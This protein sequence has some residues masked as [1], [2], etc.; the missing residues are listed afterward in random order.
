MFLWLTLQLETMQGKTLDIA[1]K[2]IEHDFAISHLE[3]M[4]KLS[5]EQLQRRKELMDINFERNRVKFGDPDYIYD[6]QVNILIF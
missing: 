1:L 4:N 5:D 2:D 3:D 6:K